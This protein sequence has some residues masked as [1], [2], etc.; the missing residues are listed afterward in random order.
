MRDVSF[1]LT[2][3]VE[4][5]DRR[6]DERDLIQHYLDTRRALG[7]SAIPFEDAW[8]AH[9]I[10]AAYGVIASF[11]S[12]VPPYNTEA[13]RMFTSNFRARAMAAIDE[14]DSVGAL[15]EAGIAAGA[16]AA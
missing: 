15:R 14:L 8:L 3:G 7:G 6:R 11:L 1:F 13:R 10:H 5:G 16:P 2:M 9:H 12:L 4:S